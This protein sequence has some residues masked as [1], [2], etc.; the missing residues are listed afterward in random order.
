MCGVQEAFT[1]FKVCGL[2]NLPSRRMEGQVINICE[3]CCF[4]LFAVCIEK[5]LEQWKSL[6]RWEK[7][8]D[9]KEKSF[10]NL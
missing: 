8:L 7:S 9:L 2:R 5:C 3:D 6:F 10:S 1:L 4:Q